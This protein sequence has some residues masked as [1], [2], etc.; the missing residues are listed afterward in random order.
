MCIFCTFSLVLIE[1][2]SIRHSIPMLDLFSYINHIVILSS[3]S[4]LLV[5]SQVSL[6]SKMV[7]WVA[8]SCFAV[9]LV[10]TNVNLCVPYYKSFINHLYNGYEG[11]MCVGLMLLFILAVFVFSI[12]LDQIRK[13]FF[14]NL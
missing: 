7:N 9:F 14:G 12:L 8:A 4:I 13:L 5:F 3:I 10:H 6:K 2:M 1:F 11:I